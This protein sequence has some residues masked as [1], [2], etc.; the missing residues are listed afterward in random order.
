[1]DVNGQDYIKQIPLDSRTNNDGTLKLR[2]L[3]AYFSPLFFLSP[4]RLPTHCKVGLTS[5]PGPLNVIMID[6]VSPTRPLSP[7]DTNNNNSNN[8]YHKRYQNRTL[9][10]S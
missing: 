10:V 1:M 3:T 9:K 8:I 2:N 7:G 5:S 4:A 6:H